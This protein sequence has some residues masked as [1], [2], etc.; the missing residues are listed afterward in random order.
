MISGKT[1]TKIN[2]LLDKLNCID[3]VKFNTNTNWYSLFLEKMENPDFLH[4]FIETIIELFNETD[5]WLI[6]QGDRLIQWYGEYSNPQKTTSVYLTLKYLMDD[7]YTTSIGE[8]LKFQKSIDGIKTSLNVKLNICRINFDSIFDIK[9][10][11]ENFG[12]IHETNNNNIQIVIK[13]GKMANKMGLILGKNIVDS[14]RLELDYSE[15]EIEEIVQ[16]FSGLFLR[17]IAEFYVICA[18]NR[19]VKFPQPN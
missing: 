10:K 9:Y 1:T 3:D 19:G 17:K 6:N 2:I 7:E 14:A 8:K 4:I 15:K 5:Y 11:L 12:K 18:I 13:A 16:F